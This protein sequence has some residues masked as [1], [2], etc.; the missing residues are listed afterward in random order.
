[1]YTLTLR[2]MQ[3]DENWFVEARVT[4]EKGNGFGEYGYWFELGELD[5]DD[6][7]DEVLGVDNYKVERIGG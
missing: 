4:D 7:A 5:I 2:D 3:E 6:W 1:M